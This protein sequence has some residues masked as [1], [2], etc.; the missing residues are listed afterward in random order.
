MRARR[1]LA[2]PQYLAA[3]RFQELY[4][5]STLGSLS[6][7]DFSRPKVSGGRMPDPLNPVR[8]AAAKR[9]RSVE[10]SLKDEYGHAGLNMTRSVLADHR[11]VEQTAKDFGAVSDREVRS[12]GWLFRKCLD[13]LAKLLG[14]STSLRR[15]PRSTQLIDGELNL[16]DPSLHADAEELG[17]LELRRGRSNGNANGK[18]RSVQ[19]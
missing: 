6:P 16:K 9:L 19:N 8:M 17:D 11:S 10:L 15:T 5:V 14:F 12:W 4:E 13:Q 7:A 1:Q 2:L 3:R 18:E